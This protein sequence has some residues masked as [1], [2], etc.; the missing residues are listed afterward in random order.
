M[1]FVEVDGVHL[2]DCDWMFCESN[3]FAESGWNLMDLWDV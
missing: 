2:H 1:M 3:D